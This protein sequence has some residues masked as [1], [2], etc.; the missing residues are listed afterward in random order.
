MDEATCTTPAAQIPPS[1]DNDRGLNFESA[2]QIEE[3]IYRRTHA[4]YSIWCLGITYT[5]PLSMPF[6]CPPKVDR[7]PVCFRSSLEGRVYRHIILA[8][9]SGKVWGALGLSR[10]DTLM[11]KELK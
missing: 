5:H 7:F 4:M 6:Y 8:V 1:C 2:T 10:R 11:Y 3:R 9:R